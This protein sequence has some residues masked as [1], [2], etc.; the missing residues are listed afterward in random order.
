MNFH[1]TFLQL[2]RDE[3][4]TDASVQDYESSASPNKTKVPTLGNFTV[5]LGCESLNL[6]APNFA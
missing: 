2:E 5:S 3:S 4:F 1:C 6:P